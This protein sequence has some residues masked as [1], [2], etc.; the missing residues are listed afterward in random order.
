MVIGTDET[1]EFVEEVKR[2]TE[3][4]GAWGG[5]DPIAGEMTSKMLSAIRS[6]GKILVYGKTSTA[7]AKLD[8]S[9]K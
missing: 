7:Y 4:E 9:P 2:I 1:P 6:K 8:V 5:I 3:G